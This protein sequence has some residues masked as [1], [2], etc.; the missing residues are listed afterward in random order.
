[1][2]TG[3]RL[4]KRS[5]FGTKVCAPLEDGKYYCGSIFEVKTPNSSAS[6]G[7]GM[8]L[9]TK[10]RFLVKFDEVPGENIVKLKEY[11]DREII[12]PGFGS[13]TNTKLVPGQKVYLTYNGR[14]IQAEVTE[15]NVKTDEVHVVFAP[16]GQ[17]VRKLF[18][19]GY[20]HYRKLGDAGF[21]KLF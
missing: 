15:H 8:P 18:F 5:I 2:S 17:E 13:I 1:M 11:H 19:S 16:S 21:Q 6:S 9:T 12:G 20:V 14:E 7:N 3:K 4:A 10:T